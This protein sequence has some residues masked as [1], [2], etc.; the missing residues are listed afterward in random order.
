MTPTI[1]GSVPSLL[2][3]LLLAAATAPPLHG[4]SVGSVLDHMAS[5]WEH[6]VSGVRDYTVV[7]TNRGD[8]TVVYRVKEMVAG[9]PVFRTESVAID[10][11][12]RPDE[13][14]ESSVDEVYTMIGKLRTAAQYAGPDT[15]D[16]RDAETLTTTDPDA[17][18]LAPQ[19]VDARGRFTP[20]TAKM[21]VDA[22][23]W[24]PLRFEWD[25]TWQSEGG[26]PSDVSMT[27]SLTDYREVKGLLEPF[28]LMVRVSGAVEAM[29]SDPEM[30]AK[31]AEMQKRIAEMPEAQ[32]AVAEQMLKTRM[33]QLQQMA[34]GD[35]T[36]SSDIV[37]TEV[38]VN[39][40]PPTP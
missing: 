5:A 21:W 16:G 34:S 33:A 18:G 3:C 26:P 7:E 37:V 24:V 28:H 39:A 17:M 9:H 30:Q 31:I 35:D 14:G 25:G 4:Q 1:R 36:T 22:E 40:G 12:P 32:R 38:R 19:D 2:L 11:Q 27:M 23:R 10:G 15:V 8:T 6:R 20:K 29:T 13:K